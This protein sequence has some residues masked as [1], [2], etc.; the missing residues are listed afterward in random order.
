MPSWDYNRAIDSMRIMT[1][2]AVEFG[3]PESSMLAGTGIGVEHLQE[4]DVIV[5]AKQELQ[6]ISNLVEQL[7]HIPALGVIAGQ[8]YHFNTFGAL[9]FAL[10]SSSTLFEALQIGLKYIQLTFAFCQFTLQDQGDV[11]HI[12][13]DDTGVPDH[14]RQFVIERDVACFVTLQREIFRQITPLVHLDL[15]VS[16]PADTSPYGDFF[17]VVPG[18]DRPSN[19]LV[20]DSHQLMRRMPQASDLAR[21][22]AEKQCETLL[23]QRQKRAGLAAEVR[24]LL[25][26][27]ASSMPDMEEVASCLN[28]IPRTLRRRLERENTSF[29]ALRDE[30]RQALAEEYLTVPR[31]SV[32]QVAERLGYASTTS[33]I[34]AYKRWYSIT[35]STRR[36]QLTSST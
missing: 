25:A 32:E 31:L 17:G 33:F 3:I 14:L 27:R 23:D 13:I 22:S 11:T 6:L 35:P 8:R 28:T 20:L 9:G 5:E 21:R 2:M 1:E 26:S 24:Q 15:A 10:V 4:P 34:N 16:E 7:G 18:F 19:R 29:A 12:G 36:T 30:V